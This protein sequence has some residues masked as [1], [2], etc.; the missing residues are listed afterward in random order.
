MSIGVVANYTQERPVNHRGAR[1]CE[2]AAVAGRSV[3][4]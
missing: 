2:P 4:R 1:Y 3:K